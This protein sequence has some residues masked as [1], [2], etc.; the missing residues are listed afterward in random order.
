MS[1]TTEIIHLFVISRKDV[2]RL[3]AA[4]FA[5]RTLHEQGFATSAKIV[6]AIYRDL[7]RD[8][9]QLEDI[10]RKPYSR[11]LENFAGDLHRNLLEFDKLYPTIL[12]WGSDS[13]DKWSPPP[14]V[15]R[16]PWRR[17][18]SPPGPPRSLDEPPKVLMLQRTQLNSLGRVCRKRSHALVTVKNYTAALGALASAPRPLQVLKQNRFKFQ[19]FVDYLRNQFNEISVAFKEGFWLPEAFDLPWPVTPE[20]SKQLPN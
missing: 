12:G 6:T 10:C 17:N 11:I 20:K 1:W 2:E 8:D 13:A 14:Q 16:Y 19:G 15:I 18:G 5:S 7:D 9:L 4:E 3:L